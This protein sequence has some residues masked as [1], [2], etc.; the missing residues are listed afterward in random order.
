LQER[1]AEL[2]VRIAGPNVVNSIWSKAKIAFALNDCVIDKPLDMAKTARNSDVR[3]LD[4]LGFRHKPDDL[5][6]I[7]WSIPLKISRHC[8]RSEA[9][10]TVS[11]LAFW[12]ASLRSQ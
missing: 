3:L 1:D 10:Q 2:R 8:E 7:A 9:I 6:H 12:I 11:A 5:V 4:V